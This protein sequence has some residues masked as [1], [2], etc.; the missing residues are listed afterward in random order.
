MQTGMA[1]SSI[2]STI[3]LAIDDA[4][5]VEADD[6]AGGHEHA[7]GVDFVD[8][9]R[10]VA[11]RVLLLLIAMSVSGSGLSMP[12]KMAK[13]FAFFIMSRSSLSSARLIDASVENSKG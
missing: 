9:R 8:A 13:K 11:P 12:T 5:G 3:A 2:N 10:N 7:G 1:L 4:L 6:E